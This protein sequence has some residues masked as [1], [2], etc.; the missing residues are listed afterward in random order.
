MPQCVYDKN[1]SVNAFLI[2][3]SGT[4]FPSDSKKK[5]NAAWLMCSLNSDFFVVVAVPCSFKKQHV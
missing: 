5:K 2:F 1:E 4:A 3:I